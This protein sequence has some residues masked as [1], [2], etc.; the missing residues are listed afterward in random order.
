MDYIKE[1]SDQFRLMSW[2]IEN[3]IKLI[4]EG[5]TIPFIA[6][7]RKE[8]HGSLDDQKLREISERLA[9]LRG[10]DERKEEV[11]ALI[12]GLNAMTDEI[13]AALDSAQ[14]L[15]EIDDI[16]RPYR[17]KRK[18]RA[19]VAKEK[20]LEPLA[21]EI[22][23]QK[24]DSKDPLIMAEA[25]INTENGVIRIPHCEKYATHIENQLRAE[26]GLP[27]RS[28]YSPGINSTSILYPGTRFSRFYTK[29]VSITG[30]RIFAIPHKY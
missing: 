18:T 1:L 2:Q 11:R 28:H 8:A 7:Y 20:G 27:L 26:H 10:L 4:D 22:F 3:V 12:I 21:N 6:R 19:S 9:Y 5:N 29:T 30:T 15:S 24:K 17:P 13:N 23:E 14:T 16:Y 25:F